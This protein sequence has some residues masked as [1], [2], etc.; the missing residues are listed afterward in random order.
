MVSRTGYCAG[1]NKQVEV[2]A[3][4]A[5][6]RYNNSDLG[7][8]PECGC[9]L[10][11]INIDA[12]TKHSTGHSTSFSS[13]ARTAD[14]A[15]ANASTVSLGRRAPTAGFH[16]H[17][18]GREFGGYRIEKFIGRGG[19]A[20]VFK[21]QHL[22][23]H[24]DCAIKVLCP[25]I[26]CESKKTLGL[27][28]DEARSAA[29]ISHPHVV[30]VHNMGETDEFHYIELEYVPGR[31]LQDLIVREGRLQTL[32]AVAFMEQA[33]AA[34]ATAHHANLVH[35]DVKPGNMLVR[36]DG[37]LKL[38]DFGLAKTIVEVDGEE[39]TLSKSLAGTPNFMAPELLLGHP[40]SFQSDAYALGVSLYYAMS[41]QFPFTGDNFHAIR[42]SHLV[43]PLPCMAEVANSDPLLAAFL[44]R[45]LAKDPLERP[46]HGQQLHDEIRAALLALRD[47]PSLVREALAGEQDLGI[48]V[49]AGRISIT[50]PVE[51]GRTQAVMIEETQVPGL[52]SPLV[53][54]FSICGLATPEIYERALSVNNQLAF[55][56]C[57]LDE[58][59]GSTML[60]IIETVPNAAC[61]PQHIR[62]SVF[63]LARQADILERL[64][65]DEDMF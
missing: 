36:P 32:D 54:I 28:I 49:V 33:A 38:A 20:Y 11:D 52:D 5:P 19:M 62:R 40:A 1:C 43:D 50:V 27:F 57:A 51:A 30:E 47:L 35:G 60:T 65:S 14:N 56:A 9:N 26:E 13:K 31:S 55:G 3:S 29:S 53:R 12:P 7:D 23:L 6:D 45:C 21:A 58:I 15:G 16:E 63:Q 2:D 64:L 41:G 34:L 18:I 39:V 22:Q 24:R 42:R 8:C 25:W 59:D 10:E 48:E 61:E 44:E 4:A 17:M 46:A 37:F